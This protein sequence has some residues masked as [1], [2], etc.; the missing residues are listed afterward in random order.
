MNVSFSNLCFMHCDGVA[1]GWIL[2]C[3]M[4][5]SALTMDGMHGTGMKQIEQMK[6]RDSLL[7]AA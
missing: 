4:A 2:F 7:R 5:W 3:S 1:G 6:L